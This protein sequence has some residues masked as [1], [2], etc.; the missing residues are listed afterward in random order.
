MMDSSKMSTIHIYA[1]NFQ[2]YI[3][4]SKIY[5]YSFWTIGPY[6]QM[7]TENVCGDKQN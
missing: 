2:N 4:T 5:S 6:L 3:L 1:D 7:I